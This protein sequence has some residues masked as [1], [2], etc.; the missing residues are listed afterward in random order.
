M[1]DNYEKVLKEELW[2]VHRYLKLH[3]DDI[4][5]M[6]TADRK[7]Y[8]SIHNSIKKEDCQKMREIYVNYYSIQKEGGRN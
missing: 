1:Y 8:I 5:N 7:L 3:M 4:Y 2:K 6:T